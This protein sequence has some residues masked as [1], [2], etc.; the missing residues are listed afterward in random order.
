MAELH[1]YYR[2]TTMEYCPV[3]QSIDE[4]HPISFHARIPPKFFHARIPEKFVDILT[5]G[6]I[7]DEK[8]KIKHVKSSEGDW[9]C[10]FNVYPGLRQND[11]SQSSYVQS[12]SNFLGP[13]GD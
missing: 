5:K 2:H 1:K 11:Y 4:H 7:V 10:E 6:V 12:E 8:N 13:R 9:G 3:F